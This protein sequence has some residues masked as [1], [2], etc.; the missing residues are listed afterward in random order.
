[1]GDPPDHVFHMINT[2]NKEVGYKEKMY[3]RQETTSI[4]VAITIS[5][6]DLNN[7]IVGREGGNCNRRY[8][9][10]LALCTG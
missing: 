2:N 9:N 4:P 3:T 6:P 5:E 10:H 7:F 1:M 8:I